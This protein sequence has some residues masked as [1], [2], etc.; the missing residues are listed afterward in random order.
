[1]FT[2]C[3]SVKHTKTT[4]RGKEIEGYILYYL[5]KPEREDFF[6]LATGTCFVTVEQYINYH[7]ESLIKDKKEV[8]IRYNKYGYVDKI[9]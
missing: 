5:T 6:G 8:D 4:S 7:V 9:I 2:I 1:M 3:G